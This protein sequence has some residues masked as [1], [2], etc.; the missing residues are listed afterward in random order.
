MLMA[1][2]NTEKWLSHTKAEHF[3]KKMDIAHFLKM[4]VA[5]LLWTF[6]KNLRHFD[7]NIMAGLQEC[8]FLDWRIAAPPGRLLE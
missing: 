1:M 8:Q 3:L 5:R 6:L 4:V 2:S 7:R